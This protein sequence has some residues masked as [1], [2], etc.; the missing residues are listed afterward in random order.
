MERLAQQRLRFLPVRVLETLDPAVEEP[1]LVRRPPEIQAPE[2]F[3]G[4]AEQALP[5]VEQGQL[6]ARGDIVRIDSQCG[7]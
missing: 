5:R 3:D 2:R 7:A 6:H 1:R 4:F